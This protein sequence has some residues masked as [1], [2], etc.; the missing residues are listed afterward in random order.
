MPIQDFHLWS[1]GGELTPIP[2]VP[3]F[4]SYLYEVSPPGRGGTHPPVSWSERRRKT[5]ELERYALL[6]R[7]TKVS[8][9]LN[10]LLFTVNMDQFVVYCLFIIG[11]VLQYK[12]G[13]KDKCITSQECGAAT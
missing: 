8:R 6:Y 5:R 4:L 13:V 10:L 7:L 11:E 3:E 1:R 9:R 2:H 12:L